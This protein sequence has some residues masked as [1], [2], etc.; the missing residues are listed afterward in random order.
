MANIS[1]NGQQSTEI[2]DAA[3][4][5]FHVQDYDS[6]PALSATAPS[7][8]LGAHAHVGGRGYGFNSPV[9]QYA[10]AAASPRSYGSRPGSR[11]SSRA[12]TPSVPPVDDNDAF[13]A[14]GPGGAKGTRKHHGKRGGHGHGTHSKENTPDMRMSPSPSPSLLRRGLV[15]TRPYVSSREQ[16]PAATAIPPPE[17]IP[18]LENGEAAN[19]AYLKARQ[20]AFK[21]GGLRNKFLQRY[22]SFHRDRL[23]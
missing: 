19:Q 22:G 10:N 21:H 3:Q 6:S 4:P 20:D 2:G 15:K 8:S 14:L 12:A 18:W 5:S 7:F 9:N 17:N 16:N 23:R 1:L 13:P 11:P